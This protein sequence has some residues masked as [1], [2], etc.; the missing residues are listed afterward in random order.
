[1][2]CIWWTV[3]LWWQEMLLCSSS[4]RSWRIQRISEELGI[5]IEHQ[6]QSEIVAETKLT[7]NTR[8]NHRILSTKN[9]TRVSHKCLKGLELAKTLWVTFIE[10]V[11][12]FPPLELIQ[13][14][15]GEGTQWLKNSNSS[16]KQNVQLGAV[17]WEETNVETALK[18]FSWWIYLRTGT[19]SRARKPYYMTKAVP[20]DEDSFQRLIMLRWSTQGY[21]SIFKKC[22]RKDIIESPIVQNLVDEAFRK[23]VLIVADENSLHVER[24]KVTD[25]NGKYCCRSDCKNN[26]ESSICSCGYFRSINRCICETVTWKMQRLTGH[27]ALWMT[28]R[29]CRLPW[30]LNYAETVPYSKVNVIG[31]ST[32]A[33]YRIDTRVDKLCHI[34][35]GLATRCYLINQPNV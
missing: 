9:E 31:I 27:L 24:L 14:A 3:V 33:K 28:K 22:R 10:R 11:K 16:R 2:W 19:I 32:D 34:Q 21:L 4:F 25:K 13:S 18:T 30:P 6:V 15:I 26:S 12:K 20:V 8:R 7:I 29:D 23:H 1:M 5:K 17:Y 35:C